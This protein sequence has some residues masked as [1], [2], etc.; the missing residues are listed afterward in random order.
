MDWT[1]IGVVLTAVI[2][3]LAGFNFILKLHL[4]PLL[5][6]QGTHATRLECLEADVKDV[7]EEVAGIKG[8][9]GRAV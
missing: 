6:V 7:R 9:L 8:S 1:M 3:I 4:K 2:S 5:V